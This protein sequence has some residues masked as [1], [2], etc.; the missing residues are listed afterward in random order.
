MHFPCDLTMDFY[1]KIRS[2]SRR[3]FMPT[4]WIF[5]HGKK[6]PVILVDASW[7]HQWLS[8][9]N[10]HNISKKGIS[11][12]LKVQTYLFSFWARVNSVNA[13]QKI[14]TGV[15]YMDGIQYGIQA[16]LISCHFWRFN[17][18]VCKSHINAAVPSFVS[19]TIIALPSIRLFYWS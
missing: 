6:P 19:S 10:D 7:D 4:I 15:T 13:A 16:I 1:R 17:Q 12:A 18:F 9:T 5:T 11:W 14:T 2:I 3:F 8:E